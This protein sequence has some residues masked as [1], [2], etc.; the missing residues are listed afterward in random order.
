MVRRNSRG[1]GSTTEARRFGPESLVR[2]AEGAG[3]QQGV[4]NR[5]VG[6]F[7]G[8]QHAHAV[9][10]DSVLEVL[11]EEKVPRRWR[12][13]RQITASQNCSWNRA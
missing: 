5:G 1:T 9:D 12:Q 10:G 11:A 13:P 3:C 7:E 8:V 6:R 4:E 2:L